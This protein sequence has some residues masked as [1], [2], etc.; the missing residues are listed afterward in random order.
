MNEY[1]DVC[2]KLAKRIKWLAQSVRIDDCIVLD[3]VFNGVSSYV[4]NEDIDYKNE[5][6]QFIKEV[7][8]IYIRFQINH[9]EIRTKLSTI[10]N[11]LPS[12]ITKQEKLNI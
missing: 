2:I 8:R 7:N 5:V 4:Y 10:L 11:F 1:N 12:D 3:D 9:S 6:N